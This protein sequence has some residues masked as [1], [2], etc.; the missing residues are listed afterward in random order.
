MRWDCALHAAACRGGWRKRF[1]SVMRRYVSSHAASIRDYLPQCKRER[2]SGS[3]LD[4]H[5]RSGCASATRS[6]RRR[7]MR[8]R[9]CNGFG[10]HSR[11][12]LRCRLASGSCVTCSAHAPG[13]QGWFGMRSPL[14][15][16]RSTRLPNARRTRRSYR[17][18]GSHAATRRKERK[19]RIDPTD[20]RRRA[21]LL[22]IVIASGLALS[23][24]GT[25]TTMVMDP[26]ADVIKVES[27]SVHEGKKTV[28]CPPEVVAVFRKT[29]EAQL[30]KQGGFVQ[31]DDLMGWTAPA[32]GIDVP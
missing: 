14:S 19:M 21:R 10:L 27:I 2:S 25:G 23:A 16:W 28:N 18:R 31:G 20:M 12:V 6:L 1:A 24:C 9:D 7:P 32:P 22:F 29:L 5:P 15:R 8:G 13:D 30:Y 11:R 26:G 3:R 4:T 17:R